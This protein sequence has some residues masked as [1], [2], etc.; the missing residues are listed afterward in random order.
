MLGRKLVSTLTIARS[1][2]EAKIRNQRTVLQR[3]LRQRELAEE[4]AGGRVAGGVAGE[5]LEVVLAGGGVG[6]VAVGVFAV[7]ALDDAADHVAGALQGRVL[8]DR[9]QLGEAAERV[10]G[11]TAGVGEACADSGCAGTSLCLGHVCV[12]QSPAGSPCATDFE[13]RGACATGDAGRRCAM[14]CTRR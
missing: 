1:L 9:P 4:L 11:A 6:E 5:L 7:V 2:V 3:Q 14:D 8:E 12:A 13:C 10:A